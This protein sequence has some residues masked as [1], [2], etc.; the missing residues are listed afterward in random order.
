L[1]GADGQDQ[2]AS[3]VV[4]VEV[5]SLFWEPLRSLF[6]QQSCSRRRVDECGLEV[7][8]PCPDDSRTGHD[9]D[10]TRH[11]ARDERP[12]GLAKQSL[13]AVS[14]GGAPDPTGHREP[15]AG[16]LGHVPG[17]MV[18]DE[19]GTGHLVATREHPAEVGTGPQ[20]VGTLQTS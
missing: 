3:H 20:A 9:D 8:E 15:H 12:G 1:V 19:L 4:H 14:H 6:S 2:R 11:E 17:C 13:R 5:P 7:A 18:Q 10:V 16:P